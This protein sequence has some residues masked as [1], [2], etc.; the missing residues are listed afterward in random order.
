MSIQKSVIYDK[1]SPYKAGFQP[2]GGNWIKLNTNENPYPPSEKVKKL[3]EE[4]V[5]NNLRLYPDGD[6]T[7]LKEIFANKFNLKPGNFFLGN[8]SDEVLAI[9]FQGFFAGRKRVLTPDITYSFYS[10]WATIYDVG[11]ETIPVN[12]DFGINT[13]DYLN[14]N[15]EITEKEEEY[16]EVLYGYVEP[17]KEVKLGV[18]GI[19][20]ANPN[21]PTSLFLKPIEIEKLLKE[22]PD[23]PVIVDEAYVDFA[24]SSTIELLNKY[25]NLIIV[26]TFSKSYSLAGMRVGYSVGSEEVIE[27]LDNIKNSFNS[28][29][30]DM[31]SQ[32]VAEEAFLD[33]GY[34]K[35]NIE[36]ICKTRDWAKKKIREMGFKVLDSATNFLFVY[37]VEAEGLFKYLFA[38]NILV[39]HWNKPKIEN[40]LRVSIGTPDEMIKLLHALARW[41]EQSI[42]KM[43]DN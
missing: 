2:K 7:R 37:D 5:I 19:I 9:I 41:K 26:R 23:I 3:L 17:K 13:A 4:Y 29:P 10:T 38:N 30:L 15:P 24:P 32:K 35:D 6:S 27:V 33:E 22:Y 1:I 36:K 18:D 34:F 28:Y 31:I 8:G 25:S 14:K 43:F 16:P 39:R 12:E 42:R 20:L 21:A 40:W 11:L